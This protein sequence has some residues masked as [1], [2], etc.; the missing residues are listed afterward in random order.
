[1][2]CSLRSPPVRHHVIYVGWTIFSP[3]WCFGLIKQKF[4]QAYVS[5][6]QDLANVV[7]SSATQQK[8]C[9]NFYCLLSTWNAQQQFILIKYGNVLMAHMAEAYWHVHVHVCTCQ[10]YY[11][12]PTSYMYRNVY[13][14][15]QNGIIMVRNVSRHDIWKGCTLVFLIFVSVVF[16]EP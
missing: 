4:R 3:N 16:C 1:M 10:Y 12:S 15:I 13:M 2:A 9:I 5:L 6:L 7:N 14:Y 8:G 11:K